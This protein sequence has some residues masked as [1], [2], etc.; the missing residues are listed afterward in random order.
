[1]SKK[2]ELSA[3][4][5]L[6]II[7]VD[8]AIGGVLDAVGTVKD[9]LKKK[10]RETSSQGNPKPLEYR[11]VVEFEIA[12]PNEEKA[13]EYLL[14]RLRYGIQPGSHQTFHNIKA[15]YPTNGGW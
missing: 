8:R 14:D 4:D 13:W 7:Y 2:D 3:L 11:A 6:A 10:A 12:A 15:L 5:D 1:M 9:K